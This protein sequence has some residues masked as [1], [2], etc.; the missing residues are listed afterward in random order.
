MEA[1]CVTNPAII[2]TSALEVC[3]ILSRAA[4][5]TKMNPDRNKTSGFLNSE[6][7]KKILIY[8]K[9]KFYSNS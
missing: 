1:N 3:K 6:S 8:C 9:L 5:A 4:I 7:T 2:N